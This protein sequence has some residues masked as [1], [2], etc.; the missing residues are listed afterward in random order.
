M[1]EHRISTRVAWSLA[2]MLGYTSLL[3]GMMVALGW[4]VGFALAV[5]SKAHAW[6]T[7]QGRALPIEPPLIGLGLGAVGRLVARLAREPVARFAVAGMVFS[8]LALVLAMLS[9]VACM[10]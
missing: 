10:K 1:R 2:L 4:T 7:G 6:M 8:G 9:M 5:P 3:F